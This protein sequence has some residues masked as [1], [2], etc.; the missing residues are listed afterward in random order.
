MKRIGNSAFLGR[1][2]LFCLCALAATISFGCNNDS[3]TTTNDDTPVTPGTPGTQTDDSL[4]VSTNKPHETVTRDFE[5]NS[6]K[7]CALDSDCKTGMF[8]F[9]GLC[10]SECSE[11]LPCAKGNCSINGRCVE[12][13]G[14]KGRDLKDDLQESADSDVVEKIPGAEV[15]VEP[16]DRVFVDAGDSVQTVSIT[17]I[18]DY[19]PISYTVSNPEDDTV[20]N[21]LT[22]E[23]VINEITN[24]AVYM[25]SLPA[26]ESSLGDQGSV[27]RVVLDTS[28][29]EFEIALAPRKPSTGMYEGMVSA[30][31]FA[32][33]GLPM[34]FAIETVPEYISS[35]DDIKEMTI[36]L[37]SSGADL[38][39]PEIVTDAANTTWSKVVMKKETVA[40]N[41]MNLDVCWSASYSVNDYTFPE[42][43]LVN[44]DQKVNRSIRIEIAGFDQDSMAF[45]GNMRDILAGV[46]REVGIDGN[47]QWAKAT[48]EGT[49][50]ASRRNSFDA[51]DY[52][53][54]T[55]SPDAE[56][57]RDLQ[58]KIPDVCTADDLTALI[59][60]AGEDCAGITTLDEYYA[61]ENAVSCLLSATGSMLESPR[62]VSK[63]I[64]EL[65]TKDASD[66]GEVE[67]FATLQDFMQ[68]CALE[69]GICAEKHEIVCAVDLLARSYVNSDESNKVQILENWHQLMR[70]SYLGRQYS[71]WQNDV[72]V[73]RKW[74]ENAS[75]P[76][77][78]AAELENINSRNLSDW[79]TKVFDAHRNVLARQFSQTSLEVLTRV[80]DNSTIVSDRDLILAE[81][82]D[83]WA[84]VSDSMSLGLRRYDELYQATTQR[85]AKAAEMRPHLFDLYYAGLV[86]TA[87]NR[88]TSNGSL[89]AS[90]GKN[91]NENVIRLR[92]LDQSFDDLVFMRDAEV[93]TST[94]L[95]PLSGNAQVLSDRKKLAKET[96]AAAQ[97]KRDKVF[98]DYDQKTINKAQI[99]ANLSNTIESLQTELVSI[100]GLP[101]GCRDPKA[102]NCAPRTEAG[103]CGFD[104]PANS[105][106]PASLSTTLNNVPS[107]SAIDSFYANNQA[108]IDEDYLK[109]FLVTEKEIR[110]MDEAER[111]ALI[112][113]KAEDYKTEDGNDKPQ[114]LIDEMV[115][116]HINSYLDDL[117]AELYTVT[118][119]PYSLTNTGEAAEAVLAYRSALKD[120]DI[121]EAE[122]TALRNKVNIAR[123]VC[124]SY[125]DNID[126][127]NENRKELLKTIQKN[128]EII[129][130]HYDN[131]TE[132]ERAKL[133]KDVELVN[134]QYE[135]QETYNSEW[136]TL[137][138]DHFTGQQ[139]RIEQVRDL[140][141]SSQSMEYAANVTSRGVE[142]LSA[143][144]EDPVDS[145][146]VLGFM[147]W[148]GVAK[149]AIAS[150]G[151][152]LVDVFELIALALNAA[153]DGIEAS[154]EIEDYRF[155]Y[156]VGQ[157]DNQLTLDTMAAEKELQNSLA[158][159]DQ[160]DT[161]AECKAASADECHSVVTCDCS[162]AAEE[163]LKDIYSEVS[164]PESIGCKLVTEW[165]VQG[166]DQWILS[167][168]NA[169]DT[170]DEVNDTIREL[171]EVQDAYNRDMQDFEFKRSEYLQMAQDLV[172]KREQIYSAQLKAYSALKH[173][174]TVVQRAM[175]LQSQ[176]D[177]A[178]DR[179]AEIN[180]LY[181]TPATIFSF[182]SDL[183]IVE[184]KIELAKER[185]YD[186]L[187]AVEYLAV[188]PFVDL[189]RA[190]YLARS[191]ND[192]DKIIDQ[193]DTVVSKCGGG[194]PN[195]AT[196]V[197]S[198]REMMGITTDFVG[199]S[200]GERFQSVIAKGNIPI[201]SLTRY[202]VDSN[203]RDLVKKGIDLR[204]GTFAVTIAQSMNLATTCNAK[205]DSIAVQIVGEDIIKE[206]AGQ[207]VTPT[208]T[209]FYDGQTQLASCQPN[210]STLVDTIGPK[211]SYGKYSTF[212]V[213]PTK[214]SP[215]A[216][217]NEYGEANITLAGKPFATSY[218]VLIDTQ[219]S[220][221]AKID[222]DKVEDIKL[223]VRYSYQDLFPNSSPC[224]GL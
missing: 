93:V 224:V 29:G 161:E 130:Q 199:M 201:N 2:T 48:M 189:R 152:A 146:R 35:F 176:Y 162:E 107:A 159:F 203:V 121:A 132:A 185:I 191:T 150:A 18:E 167:E 145:D 166:L 43:S 133:L 196:V 54:V 7:G 69:N 44:P 175:M 45:D 193:I 14:S 27:E 129:N 76:T 207:N 17:T 174:Y 64:E 204:S 187:S 39:S 62:M 144:F 1:K 58:D 160:Y 124:E 148:N 116:A 141:I 165:Y 139:K 194:T 149:G 138:S 184:S 67:G 168:Q 220:E 30:N 136:E 115:T 4:V 49:F 206:G 41:C 72:E 52:T 113:I 59:S 97:A 151:N 61:S 218:T 221:N 198:A 128:V 143:F 12:T 195:V 89:N 77:F 96:V 65:I 197:I 183:E 155:D 171:F 188:R 222:W 104:L 13:E 85:K 5:M 73:R 147:S 108:K 3:K 114:D 127:W 110:E 80:D 32:G 16:Q 118:Q 94:S 57:L 53:I 26:E 38:F 178:S 31:Q 213:E 21:L 181:S 37:P 154:K 91:L 19:G 101:R 214:I 84:G 6:T 170:L 219:I 180:N 125:K 74:L 142:A 131:I 102:P 179:L 163:D 105:I 216:K 134:K 66:L 36:Y 68:D 23:P 208:I 186:Y 78:L 135:L 126:G 106:I 51:K 210:I 182:A 164:C 20:S 173:Y 25:F 70:E 33:V 202:T 122:F 98:D 212:V 169:I 11:T 47:K 50:V 92:S 192:L 177:A 95:D 205:I 123:S 156:K 60:L 42:S 79:E 209:V 215:T 100:C 112:G 86:E 117:K 153:I 83:G 120:V 109:K 119:D 75:A 82:A 15:V 200:M 63:I 103:F 8:C 223:Q 158:V 137:A 34:R 90:Y 55:H 56:E 111:D 157:K 28:I 140:T 88:A 71:A 172:V 9:H 217:I 24:Q 99:N 46:Y 22:S 10:T 190:T 87:I 81:F 211:T 40:A